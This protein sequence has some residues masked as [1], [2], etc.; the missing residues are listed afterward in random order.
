MAT[1][2]TVKKGSGI[3]DI[4]RIQRL[5]GTD[6]P[7]V[8]LANNGCWLTGID[9]KPPQSKKISPP[10]IVQLFLIH[11]G[12]TGKQYCQRVQNR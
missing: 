4:K 10:G 9:R 3:K 12:I 2:I 6:K 8:H 5:D 11:H 1:I 7:Q